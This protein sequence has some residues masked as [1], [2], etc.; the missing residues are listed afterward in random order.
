MVMSKKSKYSIIDGVR[1]FH[2]VVRRFC[3]KDLARLQLTPTIELHLLRHFDVVDPI[4]A[5]HLLGQ[6]YHYFD[7][8]ISKWKK[9]IIRKK[10]ISLALQVAGSKFLS[11][12]IGY[13]NPEELFSTIK[14]K[15]SQA[16]RKGEIIWFEFGD[17]LRAFYSF[18]CKYNVGNC[19]LVAISQLKKK[20]RNNIKEQLRGKI[21]GDNFKIKV[22][23]GINPILTSRVV[24]EMRY[25]HDVATPIHF[26][27]YSGI[28]TPDFPNSNQNKTE[29]KYSESFWDK[30]TFIV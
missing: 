28:L 2:P 24:V 21:K 16:S 18:E 17:S 25:P 30:H 20:F 29:K 6:Q 19:N 8:T 10:D 9:K 27:A 3:L 15:I 7:F 14:R 11:S 26:T 4:Y 5:Q 12:C 13:R 23:S 22:V 1:I